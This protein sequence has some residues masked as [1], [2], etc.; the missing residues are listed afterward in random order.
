[1]SRSGQIEIKNI[2]NKYYAYYTLNI[3]DKR[4][5]REI[6]K[7]R[8]LGRLDNGN[9]V[10]NQKF[11]VPDRALQYG[12][13][14]AIMTLNRQSLDKID[15]IF[16]KYNNEIKALALIIAL[17]KSPLG[18]SRYYYKRSILSLIWPRLKIM[19]NNISYVLRYLSRKRDKFENLM[20]IKEDMLLLH[21]EISIISQIEEKNEFN[22]V[23]L[24]I[25][26][27]AISLNIINS[28]YITDKFYNI[29]KFINMTRSVNNGGVLILESGF[30]TPKNI[31]K[32]MKNNINFIIE[33]N[34]ND[35]IKIKNRFKMEKIILYR[36]YNELLKKSIFFSE[37]RIGK[38]LYYI[39]YEG[40]E[41]V[42]FIEF[43]KVR[44]L[45]M[46]ISNLDINHNLIYQAIN[47]R[48][49]ID[50]IVSYSKFRLY[51]DSVYWIDSRAIDGYVIINT[52][53]LNFYLSFF[54]HSTFIHPGRM[55][56]I[57][58]LLL[59]LS[60]VNAFIIKDDIYISKIPG[61]LRRKMETIDESINL[62][63]YREIIKR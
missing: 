46:A 53:A 31:Q 6:K 17:Y 16:D 43:K 62:D 11:V 55:S 35:I 47:L 61:E 19:N 18:Y 12:D 38:L 36:D 32:L 4:N 7:T 54:R 39:F 1:M 51:S 45:K 56:Y 59:E 8:Y 10:I 29:E 34:E 44:N 58:S 23:I 20:E 49:F 9:I 60:S 48:N 21:I 13:I 24:D 40:N 33:G 41:D 3:W 26:I 37:K 25:L 15:N 57:E 42:D 5:K 30:N 63:A 22:V 28:D 27:D 2:K 14:A 50:R 52:I